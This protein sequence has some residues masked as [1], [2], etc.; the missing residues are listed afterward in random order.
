[1]ELNETMV[2]PDSDMGS[3]FRNIPTLI[4]KKYNFIDNSLGGLVHAYIP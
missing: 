3:S 4:Y 2:A 1:M